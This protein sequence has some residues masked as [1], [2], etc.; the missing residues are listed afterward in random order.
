MQVTIPESVVQQAI[1]HAM[2]NSA[3]EVG[4]LFVLAP[5]GGVSESR[6]KYMPG[7]NA[8]ASPA[9]SIE[10]SAEWIYSVLQEGATPLA[11]FHSHPG[12]KDIPS[13]HD[14]LVFPRHYVRACFIW[15]GDPQHMCEYN[16]SIWSRRKVTGGLDVE[17]S[18]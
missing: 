4:G 9:D 12:G 17:V 18:L 1:R 13:D 5:L 16:E 6:F 11:F 8:A 15:Y 3:Q 10:L 2:S 7:Y 14:L